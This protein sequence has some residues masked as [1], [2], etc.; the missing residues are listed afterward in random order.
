MPFDLDDSDDD[1]SLP[2]SSTG[3]GFTGNG[4]THPAA[5]M[6]FLPPLPTSSATPPNPILPRLPV[7][8]VPAVVPGAPA[9]A[10]ASAVKAPTATPSSSSGHSRGSMDSPSIWRALSSPSAVVSETPLRPTAPPL[11]VPIQV[12]AAGPGNTRILSTSRFAG[13][14]AA[15]AAAS[16]ETTQTSSNPKL[17]STF[18][19]VGSAA[20]LT[21]QP[22]TRRMPVEVPLDPT[23][24]AAV[25]PT[26]SPTP[27][28][29]KRRLVRR[30]DIAEPP[31]AS[32]LAAS[33][34]SP[35]VG[36]LRKEFPAIPVTEIAR[37]L[38]NCA[39]DIDQ[40]RRRLRKLPLALAPAPAPARRP[41]VV[42]DSDEDED[43]YVVARPQPSAAP[44]PA[45]AP[46]P[47]LPKSSRGLKRVRAA[48]KPKPKPRAFDRSDEDEEVAVF[49]SGSDD[50]DSDSDAAG[51]GRDTYRDGNTE[52]DAV[53]FFNEAAEV[54][55]VEYTQCSPEQAKAI[56]ALRPFADHDDLFAKISA[57]RGVSTRLLET[58][59]AISSSLVAVD[60]VISKCDRIGTELA[61]IIETWGSSTGLTL[62]GTGAADAGANA[63]KFLLTEQPAL[64]SP[65]LQLKGYQLYG[66]SWLALLHQQGH[67]GILADD[68]GL[69]KTAQVI[70][71][72]AHM[73]SLGHRGPFLVVSP[74][75]TLENWMREFAR[76]VPGDQIAVEAY[77]GSAKERLQ[78]AADIRFA[79]PPV[80][81]VVTTYNVACGAKEDRSFLKKMKF[82][83]M[84]LDEGH[85]VKNVES[86]RYKQLMAIP[87]SFRLLL[88]G[89]PL[90]NNCQELIA[91]LTFI[92][93]GLFAE[94]EEHWRRVLK[95][96]SIENISASRLDRV[97]KTM[98]P[99][100]LRRKKL[101][102]LGELPPKSVR[103]DYCALDGHQRELYADFLAA[104]RRELV[105]NSGIQTKKFKNYLMDL[106]KAAMHELLF[107]RIYD[108]AKLR[109]V[110]KSLMQ[111]EPYWDAN[112]EHVFEDLQ[113]C[114]DFEIHCILRRFP[115][116]A[117]FALHND[118]WMR[119]AK[120]KQLATVLAECKARGDRCLIFS[121]FTM[122]LDILEAVMHTLGHN[123]VR[124]DGTTPVPERQ[125]LIDQY[126]DDTEILVFLLSTKAGG[127]GLNLTAANVVIFHDM[128]FTPSSTSQAEDRAWRLGQT[129]PVQ[130]I[131]LVCRDTVEES[132]CQR[133][134][135]KLELAQKLTLE[136]PVDDVIVEREI[137]QSIAAQ[138]GGDPAAAAAMVVDA[139]AT[140]DD[141][142]GAALDDTASWGTD[143]MIG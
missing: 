108:D 58:F 114:S 95:L 86:Q 38:L 54:A 52:Q 136:N 74:A 79:D 18:R 121:Q 71:Y 131:K 87:A 80:N 14:A 120:V 24:S 98:M 139:I 70:A 5:A 90:Q 57:T 55:I 4:L 96:K 101:Q 60:K 77:A 76:W 22:D 35:A 10:P 49:G 102:V 45:P 42:F 64:I 116:T 53:D 118:E 126:Q 106:R 112:P 143:S 34:N 133:Q 111:E 40:T 16:S 44:A 48:P 138:L 109:D 63:P 33:S 29:K 61:G 72:I 43:D 66:V 3:T 13:I 100:V 113:V 28:H 59:D 142:K 129:R 30:G 68:M 91:L 124:L 7:P 140:S 82:E 6:P 20:P 134:Q 56:T 65:D 51:G 32:A 15:S 50:D 37:I 47:A 137:L 128:D 105:E 26:G 2:S 107:R 46:L 88:T 122:A 117:K 27:V 8:P 110:A 25:G 39:D 123:Y 94:A 141:A 83:A 73:H 119:S 67:S 81:V 127:L 69:G 31:S 21:A 84:I 93:P 89:T 92:L 36:V 17:S 12:I 11:T 85:M 115:R 78:L 104:S 41:N 132:I 62:T 1:Y 75:S 135:A 97:K 125:S 103:I 99:F 130:V 19:P 23:R 9:P